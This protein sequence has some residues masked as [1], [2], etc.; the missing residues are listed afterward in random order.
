MVSQA[1]ILGVNIDIVTWAEIVRFC[2]QALVQAAPQMITTING[3]IIL[4]ATKNPSYKKV[5]NTANLAI[6]DSTNVVWMGRLKGFKFPYRTPGSEL[7]W[8]ICEIA[9]DMKKS[10][11]F[12]GGAENTAQLTAE[13]VQERFPALEIAGFSN[14]DPSEQTALEVRKK[15]PDVVFV[16]YGAPVQELWIA[17]NKDKITAK[18]MVGVGGT[19][20]MVSG[21][22][23]RAPDWMLK[24]HLE[25]LW[26]LYLQPKRIIRIFKAVIIFPIR[27]LFSS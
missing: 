20:D 11:Y 6:A 24:M 9:E 7:F 12:L 5:L 23:R 3:E 2:K 17:Q 8:E 25:W 21:K 13:K 19:F 18:I 4:I 15:N 14:A 27:V 10:V 16:A 26:R 22:L 1:K